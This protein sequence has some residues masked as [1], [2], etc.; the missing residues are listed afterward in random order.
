MNIRNAQEQDAAQI[1]AVLEDAYNID[2][3]QEGITIFKKEQT[4]GYH[5][6][7]AEEDN[8]IVGITTW[9][10]HGLPK[11]QLAEL[12]RIAVLKTHQGKGLG[13]QLFDALLKEASKEYE[14]HNQKLRKLYLLTHADNEQ[15]QTF[16]KKLGM[17]QEAIL[18][19]HFYE[20][21]D[22]FIFSIFP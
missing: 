21:K 6:L 20:G 2:S 16:Y 12:D 22:E 5:Y 19:N 4:K 18:K 8:K 7:V 15:A 3:I 10:M 11:H 1:A 9:Q 17:Q 14:K 13:K